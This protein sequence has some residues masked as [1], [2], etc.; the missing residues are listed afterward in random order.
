MSQVLVLMGAQGAGKGTQAQ[1][2]SDRYSLPIVATGEILRKEAKSDTPLGQHIREVQAAGKFVSDDI[3]ARVVRKRTSEEDC[4]QGYILDGFPRTLPQ[5]KLLEELAREQGHSLMV[6]NI[7]V[8]RDLLYKRLEGRRTCSVCGRIY[9][10]YF[11]PS[12]Q[13][14]VCDIDGGTLFIRDD[15][16]PEAIAKRLALYDEQTRPLLDYFSQSGL[17][18]AIDGNGTPEE[19]FERVVSVVEKGRGG[20]SAKS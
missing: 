16:K 15:D 9:N 18:H 17:V 2:V 10:V 4:R 14:G 19:V 3:L 20:L 7:D 6:I 5:A 13:E 8:P 11:S 12:K 1:M